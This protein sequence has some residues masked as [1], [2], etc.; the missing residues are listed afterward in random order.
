ME[1]RGG[2]R[3]RGRRGGG[4]GGHAAHTVPPPV[5]K[6]LAKLTV[7]TAGCTRNNGALQNTSEQRDRHPVE[8]KDQLRQALGGESVETSQQ[9]AQGGE[10]EQHV[11]ADSIQT[12]AR[13]RAT[14]LD[15]DGGRKYGPC[16]PPNGYWHE[17]N[18]EWDNGGIVYHHHH[19]GTR[20]HRRGQHRGNRKSWHQRAESG[21]RKEEVL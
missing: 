19:R 5:L 8:V 10:Q 7:S 11:V 12:G 2:K 14:R 3:D 13:E 9:D 21:L 16:G 1:F 18:A 20:G 15:R 6:N 4:R 17:R